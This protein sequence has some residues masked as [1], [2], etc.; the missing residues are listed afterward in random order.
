MEKLTMKYDELISKSLTE[1]CN[2]LPYMITK[3]YDQIDKDEQG[4]DVSVKYAEYID[5]GVCPASYSCA[6]KELLS[7]DSGRTEDT[8]YNKM[9]LGE[10]IEISVSYRSM[11]SD[12]LAILLN[13]FSDEY[14]TVCYFDPRK[15]S[16]RIDEFYLGETSVPLYNGK[17]GFWDSFS[18]TLAQR[19]AETTEV[20]KEDTSVYDG[21]EASQIGEN[22]ELEEV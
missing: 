2:P 12:N 9:R 10:Y 4:N 8:T 16:Y 18:L 3:V 19:K 21:E 17:L 20:S 22:L 5:L 7:S 14:V 13:N 1:L 15:N 11:N 6:L